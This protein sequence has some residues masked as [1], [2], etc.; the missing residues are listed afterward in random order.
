MSNGMTVK[1]LVYNDHG[2]VHFRIVTGSAFELFDLLSEKVE[3]SLVK[4]GI[5]DLE[6]SKIVVLC[7]AYLH[8]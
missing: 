8:I 4:D 3:P 7:G 5:G 6:D 1:R 2:V